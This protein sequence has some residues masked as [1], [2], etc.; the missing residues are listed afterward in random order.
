M[1]PKFFIFI[2]LTTLTKKVP[3]QDH[4]W[5]DNISYGALDGGQWRNGKV[6]ALRNILVRGPF[7]FSLFPNL[8][9]SKKFNDRNTLIDLKDTDG[10]KT[11]SNGKTCDKDK[12]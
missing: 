8:T 9:K 2:S 3:K 7:M 1:V 12:F 5:K 11:I 6:R 10:K 4:I